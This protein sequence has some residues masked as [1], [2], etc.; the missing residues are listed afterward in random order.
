MDADDR[1]MWMALDL[2][3]QGRGRTS[4]NP[5]VGAVIVQ[6]SEV[7]GS[8]YHQGAGGPHAE[9]IALKKAG[10]KAEGATL[11]VN[12]E[13]CSHH[14]RTGPCTEAIIKAGISRV[15][16]AMQDPNP[17]VSGRGFARLTEA[18][19]KVKEGVLEDK[20]FH[21][22]EAFIKYITTGFP[23]VS[24]KVAISLDGKIAT[25]A[26]DSHWITGEKSRQFVHRLRDHSDAIVVGIET[27]LKDDPRLTARLEGGGGKDP[28]KVVVDSTARLPLDAQVINSSTTAHTV[29][30]VTERAPQEKCRALREKGVEVLMLP[31]KDGRVDLTALIKNL[32]GRELVNVLVEGGGTLN[33]SL[34]DVSLVDKLFIFIAPL[35]I[36]GR[37]SPTAFAGEGIKKIDQAW[38]VRDIELKQFDQDLL[39]IGY[40]V[41]GK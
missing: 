6:G 9:I 36:G 4:P 38:P 27:V 15:V 30:A 16:A 21:L 23:F 33:Y 5:M 28:L 8:G 13:P 18:G 2:A 24:V 34:L 41:M 22:N 12:L 11:Y 40:P 31:A 19:I 10:E 7:V 20:A 39:I 25:A 29:L 3:R 32:A 17:L 1:F 26:G 35:L 37:E 14:G